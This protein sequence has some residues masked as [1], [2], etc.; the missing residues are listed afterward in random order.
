M[1]KNNNFSFDLNDKKMKSKLYCFHHAGGSPLIFK[2]WEKFY[3]EIEVIPIDIP[4]RKKK[5]NTQ[6]FE[7]LVMEAASEIFEHSNGC[8]IFIYGHSLG[9]LF[10]FQTAYELQEKSN[11]KVKKVFVAGRQAPFESDPCE[12]KCSEGIEALYKRLIKENEMDK[13]T[14]ENIIFKQEF[15]PLIFDDYRISEEYIYRGERLKT[16]IITLSG[17]KDIAAT[18]EIMK[19]WEKV[20]TVGIKQYEIEGEHFFPYGENE[21]TVL[22]IL[23]SEMREGESAI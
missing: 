5:M 13:K 18:C 7:D 15:L 22:N 1:K 8:K 23:L 17:S 20:T 11:E 19:L 4:N 9:A 3:R 14:L 21:K 16:R 10:A 2:N 12:Y 6:H